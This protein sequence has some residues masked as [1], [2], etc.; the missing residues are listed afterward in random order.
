MLL[1]IAACTD[2]SNLSGGGDEIPTE[3]AS[4]PR[5]DS[6]GTPIDPDGGG[7]ITPGGRCDASKPFGPPTLVAEFDPEASATKSAVLT[8]DELEAFYLRYGGA[9]A[10]V[11]DLRH[12]RRASKDAAWGN[13][14]TD[15]LTPGAQGFL[16]VTAAGK[17]LYYWTIGQ[18]YRAGRAST[19][20]PFGMGATYTS[21]DA[22]WSFVVE[23]DDAV[24]FAKLA[25]GGG[26]RF[27]YRAPIDSSGYSFSQS[28]LLPNVHV[29][30]ASDMRPVLNASETIMY[31]GSNRPGGRGLDDVWVARRSTKQDEL[32]PGT[33]V[34]ELST[35]DPD[36]VTW[37][38]DDDCIVMLDRASHVYT[39]KRP[40]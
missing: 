40:L 21:P 6:G 31:F 25:E 17:K 37:V 14:V 8:P 16:S 34:R 38:S 32:G 19:A 33:H 12:A 18:N 22:A 7:P 28:K 13:V 15:A 1:G 39:A 11:W 9:Q 5:K 2:T 27:I 35:E 10:G 4:I 24:Y 26:E 3:D 29:N 20:N 30:G 23:A 36:Y